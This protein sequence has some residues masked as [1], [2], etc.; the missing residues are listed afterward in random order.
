MSNWFL[1]NRTLRRVILL[2]MWLRDI[3]KP[4][5]WTVMYLCARIIDAAS[6]FSRFW[7][8]IV[9]PFMYCSI[10]KFH[11]ISIM[12]TGFYFIWFVK[13]FLQANASKIRGNIRH[14]MLIWKI[15]RSVVWFGT[16]TAIKT[17]G[18][19]PL[20]YSR[21]SSFVRHHIIVNKSPRTPKM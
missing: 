3:T 14:V 9:E 11:I 13:M 6:F 21:P 4:D 12:H 17:C 7:Y 20:T 2:L 1:T 18:V 19:K 10:L 16:D 15:D 5:N 8:L